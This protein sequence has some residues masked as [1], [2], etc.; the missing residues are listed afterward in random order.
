MMSCL[1]QHARAI[2]ACVD[3]ARRRIRSRSVGAARGV[4]CRLLLPVTMQRVLGNGFQNGQPPR[5]FV[6]RVDLRKS[7]VNVRHGCDERRAFH[8][9]AGSRLPMKRVSPA[10]IFVA[11]AASLLENL[12]KMDCALMMT[13]PTVNLGEKSVT[14]G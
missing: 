2:S 3:D 12:E 6:D 7:F 1:R 11:A 5:I 10:I 8:E 14:H 4:W 13:A 9:G